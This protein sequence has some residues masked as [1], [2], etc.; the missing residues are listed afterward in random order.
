MSMR[1]GIGYDIHRLVKGRPLWLGGVQIPFEKGLDGHS[2]ADAL[3][4]AITDALLGAAALPDI[5]HY[6]PPSDPSIK[7]ISSATMLAKAV[8]EVHRLGYRVGNVDSI[9]IAEVPKVAP[10]REAMRKT[11]A[12]ILQIS[13]SDVQVKGKT[14]EGLG[15]IGKGDAIAAQSVVLLIHDPHP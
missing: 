8:Q 2:D 3:L 6:F 4:H 1:T 10:F 9:V 5:G 15:D 12:R 13:A 11:I 7:G 14:H